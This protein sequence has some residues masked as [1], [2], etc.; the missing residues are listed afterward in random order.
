LWKAV[1][2]IL[3]TRVNLFKRKVVEDPMCQCYKQ[4]EETIIHVLWTYLAAMDVW[5][6]GPKIFQKTYAWGNSFL[7]IM[8]DFFARFTV[9]EN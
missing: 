9:A 6:S 8:I 3:P 7:E 1:N 4:E 5:G 2:N